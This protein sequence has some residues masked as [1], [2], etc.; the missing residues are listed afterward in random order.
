MNFNEERESFLPLGK[1]FFGSFV[2]IGLILG[3]LLIINTLVF[4]GFN[5]VGSWPE[6]TWYLIVTYLGIASG[7]ILAGMKSCEKGW[8]SGFGV[9]I[10]SCLILVVFAL[11]LGQPINWVIFFGK[12]LF[13]GL[14]GAIGGVI[15]VNLR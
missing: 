14:V 11:L 15:G 2:G 8:I 4:L 5:Q 10:A 1:I 7:A 13:A 6:N 9:G 3:Q 12:T